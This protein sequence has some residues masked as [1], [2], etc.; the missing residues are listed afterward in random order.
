MNNSSM[1]Q[2][3]NTQ[4]ESPS[5]YVECE[6]CA[7]QA[8]CQP[9]SAQHQSLDLTSNYLTRRVPVNAYKHSS[10]HTQAKETQTAESQIIDGLLLK[11][12]NELTAIY[13]VCSGIFKLYQSNDDGSENIVGFRFPGELI[14]EDAIYLKK[15]NYSAIAIGNSS[16]CEVSVG[17]LSACGQLAPEL[18]QNLIHLLTKQ[19]FEHQ[20]NTQALIGRK[21]T[22]SLLAAFLLNIISRNASRSKSESIIDLTISRNDMANFLGV[23]RETL[24]RLLSK[25]QKELL[26]KFDG[27]RLELL[28]IEGLRN[29][30]AN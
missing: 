7:M 20:Q 28:S 27:K 2:Q 30:T 11:Q 6:N 26:I 13:A 25:F 5:N 23:R 29:I 10:L 17:Q 3:H 15:Y 21:S 14:G 8:V 24:S 19:S 16:V 4:N 12:A 9:L 18:Q 1:T 22:E